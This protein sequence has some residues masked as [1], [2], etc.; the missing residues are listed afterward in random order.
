MT[1][2]SS[3]SIS[4]SCDNE[5]PQSS[6]NGGLCEDGNGSCRSKIKGETTAI[7][8]DDLKQYVCYGCTIVVDKMNVIPPYVLNQ[9]NQL[10]HRR[11]MENEIKDFLL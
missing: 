6:C 5:A 9:I 7:T 11:Q 8:N 10:K 1:D 4:G 2:G 3:N